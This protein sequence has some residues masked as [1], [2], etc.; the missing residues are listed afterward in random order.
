MLLRTM[1]LCNYVEIYINFFVELYN[2]TDEDPCCYF[3]RNMYIS[4]ELSIWG[5]TN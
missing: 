4:N 1:M 5:I 3:K 2:V